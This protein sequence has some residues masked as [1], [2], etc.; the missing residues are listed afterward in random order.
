MAGT[1]RNREIITGGPAIILV[2]PQLGENIG[3]VARAMAKGRVF[4]AE[5]KGGKRRIM[6]DSPKAED[7]AKV[8]HPLDLVCQKWT[9]SPYFRRVRFVLRR[10]AADRIGDHRALE[11]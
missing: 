9:A 7:R 8:F 1:N 5:A 4:L 3:M 6:G 11:L 10:Q 2:E